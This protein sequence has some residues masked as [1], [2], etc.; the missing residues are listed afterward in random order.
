M[1]LMLCQPFSVTTLRG[2]TTKQS[3][4]YQEEIDP[5]RLQDCR[6]KLL[7]KKLHTTLIIKGILPDPPQ[8]KGNDE[9]NRRL[10]IIT[11]ANLRYFSLF[12]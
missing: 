3:R 8:R 1:Q 10:I 6:T 2:G 4:K 11:A 5:R 12:N 9:T 7:M